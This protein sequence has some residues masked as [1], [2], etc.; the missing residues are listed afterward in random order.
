MEVCFCTVLV[1]EPPEYVFDGGLF[2]VRDASGIRVMRPNTLLVAF[3][4]CA[5]AI[6]AYHSAEYPTGEIVQFPR[7]AQ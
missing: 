2:Y 5:E 3:G 4:R 7:S 1:E 6:Q